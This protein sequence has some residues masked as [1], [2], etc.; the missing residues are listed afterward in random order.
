MINGVII[1]YMKKGNESIENEQ[2]PEYIQTFDQL[3]A[4]G[5]VGLGKGKK[6]SFQP[7]GRYEEGKQTGTVRIWEEDPN[8]LSISFM[9]SK[10]GVKYPDSERITRENFDERKDIWK[11]GDCPPLSPSGNASERG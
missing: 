7:W 3:A 10:V 11:I 8:Q 9:G 4:L 5:A 2:T 1:Y 6:V